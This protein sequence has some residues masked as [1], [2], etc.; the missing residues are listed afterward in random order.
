MENKIVG[1]ALRGRKVDPETGKRDDNNPN[2]VFKK[3]VETRKDDK[4]N[5]MTTVQ[6]DSMVVDAHSFKYRKLSC[7]EAERL[8]TLPD[9][10]TAGESNSQRYRMI[11]NGWNVETIVV[12]FDALKVE[13]MRRKVAA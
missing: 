11:G 1:G 8:Q 3:F 12:F 9:N 10:Y 6:T 2:G 13:L 7:I 4:A 5:C